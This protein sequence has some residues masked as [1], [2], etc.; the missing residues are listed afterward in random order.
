MKQKSVNL[1]KHMLYDINSHNNAS[2]L[3]NSP[4]GRESAEPMEIGYVTFFPLT[5]QNVDDKHTK[6]K[7]EHKLENGY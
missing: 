6:E 1:T 5:V 4:P 7:S 3:E 2:L